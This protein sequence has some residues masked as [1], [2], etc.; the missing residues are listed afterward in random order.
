MF[1]VAKIH[2]SAESAKQFCAIRTF[3][4]SKSNIIIANYEKTIKQQLFLLFFIKLDK[5]VEKNM[6]LCTIT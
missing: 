3:T 1:H 4:A 5:N 2:F 6:Y